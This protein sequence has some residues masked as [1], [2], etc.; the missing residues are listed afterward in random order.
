MADDST[1][2]TVPRKKGPGR[3]F[4]PGISGNP[5][6]HKPIPQEAK[7]LFRESAV[8]C[9]QWLAEIAA[10]K[11]ERTADRIKAM[12]IITDRAWGPAVVPEQQE[13]HRAIVYDAQF[14]V[15]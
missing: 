12:Q 8:K 1:K 2:S 15:L 14:E 5:G 9:A 11:N 7:E 6:G 13:E 4:L 3:P 10:N